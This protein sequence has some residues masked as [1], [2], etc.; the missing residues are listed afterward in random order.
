[1]MVGVERIVK[2]FRLFATI[3]SYYGYI[4]H[5]KYYIKNNCLMSLVCLYPLPLLKVKK[6]CPLTSLQQVTGFT[7]QWHYF[8]NLNSGK[9]LD[10]LNC[11]T[12]MQKGKCFVT[13]NKGIQIIQ[14]L[15]VVQPVKENN[16]EFI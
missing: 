8:H 12:L 14:A 10:C 9:K 4:S 5:A 7:H 11:I 13:D 3:S 6:F 2:Y 1:M 16:N 15:Y